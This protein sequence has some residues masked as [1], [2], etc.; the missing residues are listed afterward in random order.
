RDPRDGVG[1]A[2]WS[3][4]SSALRSSGSR[5]RGSS[6]ARAA[7]ST[8]SGSAGWST[9]PSSPA[10]T[11]TRTSPRSTPARPK[12]R[13]PPR[14]PPPPL[15]RPYAHGDLGPSDTS[16]A[17]SAPGVLAVIV[18]ADIPYNPLP[19]AW[20]A[21]GASGIQ[22]NVNVPRILATDSVKWT[23]EGVAAVVAET[24]AQA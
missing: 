15:R 4:T 22:N 5:T 18:G 24:S 2:T 6:P 9:S 8:T 11:R 20:P 16:A 3:P 1:G 23:G 12:P 10:P 19:M 21:G 7:T 14:P 13:P 17:K